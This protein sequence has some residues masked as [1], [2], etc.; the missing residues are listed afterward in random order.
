MFLRPGEFR[1]VLNEAKG[2]I[3]VDYLKR[4]WVI[5]KI[6]REKVQDF[7]GWARRNKSG[8]ARLS[9][10]P[11][12]IREMKAESIKKAKLAPIQK[13]RTILPMRSASGPSIVIEGSQSNLPGHYADLDWNDLRRR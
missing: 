13:V 12:G 11:D 1:T 10:L 6:K 3:V 5:E 9:A 8:R 4:R 2:C 7:I